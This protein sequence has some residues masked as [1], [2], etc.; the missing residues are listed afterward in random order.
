MQWSRFLSIVLVPLAYGGVLTLA[1][2]FFGWK[3]A[4]KDSSSESGETGLKFPARVVFVAVGLSIAGYFFLK[5]IRDQTLIFEAYG[6]YVRL[7]LLWLSQALLVMLAGVAIRRQR[8]NFGPKSI[9]SFG[10]IVTLGLQISIVYPVAPEIVQECLH[11]TG[12]LLQTTGTTC[13]PACVANVCR[14]FGKAVTE[15]DAAWMV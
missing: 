11:P 14:F 5:Y 7:L 4:R 2:G 8:F 1:A 6:S 15:Q 10:I 13:G 3:F 9:V 12:M